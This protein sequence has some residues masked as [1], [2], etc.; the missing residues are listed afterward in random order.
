MREFIDLRGDGLDGDGDDHAATRDAF[1]QILGA[2]GEDTSQTQP[3][4]A[5][6]AKATAAAKKAG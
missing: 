5:V 1:A 6:I 3:K 2:I 4:K